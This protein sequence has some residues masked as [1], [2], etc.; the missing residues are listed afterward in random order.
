MWLDQGLDV[1]LVLRYTDYLKCFI[2][3]W[4]MFYKLASF[5]Q[6]FADKIFLSMYF[7]KV[8]NGK[9][10]VG[11]NDSRGVTLLASACYKTIYV[12]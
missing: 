8:K 12:I 7:R 4:L 11:M 9:K 6:L 10:H 2:I 5:H 1:W 3:H